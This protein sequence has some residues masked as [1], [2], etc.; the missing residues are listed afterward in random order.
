VKTSVLINTCNHA[1]YLGA[2]LDSVLR[3]THAADEI[4]VYDDGSSDGGT[5]ILRGYEAR[6]GGL[7]R[8]IYGV[9][10][11]G[12]GHRNQGRAVHEAFRASS[13]DVIFLLDGDDVFTPE[14]IAACLRA[15]AH[16]P[17]PVLVQAPMRWIDAQGRPLRRM[18]ERFKHVADPLAT[19]YAR[20]D[21]DL[22]YPT[23][24]LAFS[25][26]F[27][28]RALPIDWTDEIPLWIDTRLCLAALLAGPITTLEEELGGWRQ[29]TQ[30]NSAREKSPTY[31]V[32]Q[33]LRRTRVFNRLCVER[34]RP[35][36]SVWR[37]LRFYG[38]LVRLA[39]PGFLFRCWYERKIFGRDET[40]KPMFSQ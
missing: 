9:R 13:G 34:G 17:R 35:T 7:V 29:H 14:K 23:S 12:P 32:R 20:Q 30:S 2:C 26:E 18:P 27:L 8:G 11:G 6:G 39:A 19:A 21:P 31:Q 36:I 37:N 1:P 5:D 22:F 10:G 33:T 4:V 3:Q 24:A 28:T 38:Q 15:F 25:R 40:A 16:A